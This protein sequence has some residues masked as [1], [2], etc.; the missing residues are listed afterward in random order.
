MSGWSPNELKCLQ[1]LRGGVAMTAPHRVMLAAVDGMTA[2]RGSRVHLLFRRL[3]FTPDG[4]LVVILVVA[5]EFDP[6]RV[7]DPAGIFDRR[8]IVFDRHL[9]DVVPRQHG[10]GHGVGRNLEYFAVP[11]HKEDRLRALA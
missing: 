10:R 5:R 9:C 6:F 7:E 3:F 8:A 4:V 2:R 1:L 11:G